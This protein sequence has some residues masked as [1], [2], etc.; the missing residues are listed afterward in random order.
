MKI[1]SIVLLA[2]L[3]LFSFAAT[4][5][6]QLSERKKLSSTASKPFETAL[7]WQYEKRDEAISGRGS[8][9]KTINGFYFSAGKNLWHGFFEYGSFQEQSGNSTLFVN[10]KY[11]NWIAGAQ[12]KSQ[13][14]FD[15]LRPYLSLGLGFQQETFQ[16]GVYDSSMQDN[17]RMYN[18]GYGAIGG[19]LEWKWIVLN[20]EGRMMFGEKIEPSPTMSGLGRLGIRLLW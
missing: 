11:E 6:V 4:K 3:P 5:V 9:L 12:L 1:L 16:L 17:S 10:R 8:E 19:N 15:L 18:I 7:L 20:L 2:F 14:F 13:P